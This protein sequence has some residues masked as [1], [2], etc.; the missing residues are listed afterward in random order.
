[1]TPRKVTNGDRSGSHERSKDKSS[2]EFHCLQDLFFSFFVLA[3]SLSLS[4]SP[5]VIC[6]ERGKREKE[7]TKKKD[8]LRSTSKLR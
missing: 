8:D 6:E 4:L 7:K 1:M 5:L 3:L 2:L